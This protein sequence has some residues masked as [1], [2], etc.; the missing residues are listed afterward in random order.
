MA[1]S[2]QSGRDHDALVGP[3]VDKAALRAAKRLRLTNRELAEILG[4]SESSLSRAVQGAR[5]LSTD[6]KKQELMV[7]F[8]RF[9]RA[10]DAIVGGDDA[11]SAAWMRANNTA[12]N[13][14]PIDAIKSIAGLT[15]ALAYLDARR[16]VV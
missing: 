7:L 11:A 5:P 12:L 15:G 10:L 2:V 4:V 8:I 6:G 9:Y 16:A 3:I 13:S 14:R 1:S